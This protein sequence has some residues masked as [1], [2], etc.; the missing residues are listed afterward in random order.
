MEIPKEMDKAYENAKKT[1]EKTIE[2]G[3]DIKVYSHNDCDGIS[4]GSILSIML[5]RLNKEHEIEFIS[6]DKLEN[7]E[8][9]HELTIFSDLGSG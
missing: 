9:E 6:L 5:D 8:L 1:I 4:A 7:L 3:K 2:N